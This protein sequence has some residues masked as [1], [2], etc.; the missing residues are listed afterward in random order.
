MDFNGSK[1]SIQYMDC[2]AKLM[3]RRIALFVIENNTIYSKQILELLSIDSKTVGQDFIAQYKIELEQKMQSIFQ[4]DSYNP[5]VH[6]LMQFQCNEF[7]EHCLI[8]S[9]LTCYDSKYKKICTLLQNDMTGAFSLHTA[10]ELFSA[11]YTIENKV[12]LLCT[13]YEKLKDFVFEK[14]ESIINQ[15]L[16]PKKQIVEFLFTQKTVVYENCTVFFP[17]EAVEEL[18]YDFECNQKLTAILQK[19]GFQNKVLY[20]WGKEG[21]GKKFQ[22]KHTGKNLN[23]PILFFDVQNKT[24]EDFYAVF[25]ETFLLQAIVCILNADKLEKNEINQIF[26]IYKR[27]QKAFPLVFLGNKRKQGVFIQDDCQYYE[28]QIEEPNFEHCFSIWKKVTSSVTLSPEINLHTTARKFI[29]TPKEIQKAVYEASQRAVIEN[30]GIITK[31]ILYES[32][33]HQNTI[34]LAQKASKIKLVYNWNDIVLEQECKEM[35]FEA[36]SRIKYADVVYERWG[37]DSKTAYG[38]GVT[39]LLEG[40]SGTGKTMAAQ[41]MAKELELELYKID[42]SQ[43]VSKYIGE[44]EKNLYSLFEEASKNHVILFFDEAD[45][46]LGKRS[47]V[48]DSHDKYANIETDF[49]LQ[50]LEDYNGMVLFATNYIENIDS[51]FMRRFH[52]IVHFSFPDK[53]LR[54]EIWKSVFPKQMP[55]SKSIEYEYLGNQFELSGGSIKNAA[56]SAA[57]LAASQHQQLQMKHIMK[58]VIYEITKQGK[59]LLKE[60]L[61]EYYYFLKQK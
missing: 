31:D 7:E 37:F 13:M 56:L 8:L 4:M 33:Y 20:F 46:L 53:K 49:F 59:V 16:I 12:Q 35:L 3:N 60:D 39:V 32:C 11:E 61:G 55:K 5:F 48:K 29:V 14:S 24:I 47:Q 45:A 36:C 38:K 6:L 22:L 18:L 9:L 26:S 58:A 27:L 30:N 50:K 57:F 41:V 44:T 51:A 23:C 1:R 34:N 28:M 52:Y 10:M 2:M 43:M 15:L 21:I 42:L 40:P 19:G 54:T 17:H 25:T